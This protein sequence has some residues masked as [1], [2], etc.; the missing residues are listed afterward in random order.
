MDGYHLRRAQL[1]SMPNAKEAHARRGAPWTFD[2]AAFVLALA[3]LHRADQGTLLLGMAPGLEDD[4]FILC[5]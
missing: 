4:M 1:D 2:G 3:S 5:L